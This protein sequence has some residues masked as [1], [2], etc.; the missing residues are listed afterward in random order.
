MFIRLSVAL[1]YSEPSSHGNFL[2]PDEFLT[3]LMYLMAIAHGSL[4][5]RRTCMILLG[6]SKDGAF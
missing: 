1:E 5:V 3:C 4:K 6:S 2:G